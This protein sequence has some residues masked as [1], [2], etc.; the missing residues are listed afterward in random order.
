MDVPLI[1]DLRIVP[2][3]PPEDILKE[4]DGWIKADG[5]LHSGVWPSQKELRLWY[6]TQEQTWDGWRRR[7]GKRASETVNGSADRQYLEEVDIITEVDVI[8]GDG[9]PFYGFER[10]KGDKIME[11]KG[12]RWESVDLAYRRGTPCG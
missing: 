9:P 7:S 6:K 12:Q 1:S 10:V 5:D 2:E 4:L 8:F 11:A 3:P